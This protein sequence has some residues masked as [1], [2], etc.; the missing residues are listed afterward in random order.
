MKA[1]ALLASL[2]LM[3]GAAQ[4]V[5]IQLRPQTP[6]LEALVTAFLKGLS[7]EGTTLTLDKSAGPL[8]TVGG[9]VAFNADVSAR[10]YTVGGERRIEFNPAGPLPLADAVRAEL[11]KELGLSDLT[12]EAAR[13]R[14]SGA[15]LNGD[16]T[17]NITDLAILMG[18]FGQ[19]GNNMKGDLNSDGHID[20]L[21][22][23]L[24]SAQYKLP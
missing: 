20:D 8:L 14:Y 3:L 16:G 4:A 5:N 11:Q 2:A 9:K 12:P 1:R 10:S 15:D 21:D 7:S 19:S 17:I 6:E 18:N 13:L 22:L 23:N 24:F